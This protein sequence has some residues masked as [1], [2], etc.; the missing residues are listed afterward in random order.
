MSSASFARL[1]T[2]ATW[3]PRF[4]KTWKNGGSPTATAQISV[5]KS[6]STLKNG[7]T[8]IRNTFY[9]ASFNVIFL[10]N[11]F[12]AE[13]WRNTLLA[14]KLRRKNDHK[15]DFRDNVVLYVVLARHYIG[16]QTCFV[17][18]NINLSACSAPGR[19]TCQLAHEDFCLKNWAID[20]YKIAESFSASH[21]R[22][23]L[24]VEE[25]FVVVIPSLHETNSTIVSYNAS[26]VKIHIQHI[27]RS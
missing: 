11:V 6:G 1:S 14:K 4:T 10:K 26:V 7:L 27:K 5:K 9:R 2:G 12:Y 15:I 24:L 25:L 19:Q 13:K 21:D 18:Y 20:S 8:R 23:K 3:R 16:R 22:S 17:K